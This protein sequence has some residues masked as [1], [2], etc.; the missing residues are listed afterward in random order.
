MKYA[1]LEIEKQLYKL[2]FAE[3]WH[4]RLY[5]VAMLNRCRKDHLWKEAY[6]RLG[7]NQILSHLCCFNKL[8]IRINI[9][10]WEYLVSL[11]EKTDP[12]NNRCKIGA[13]FWMKHQNNNNY[14]ESVICSFFLLKTLLL[15]YYSTPCFFVLQTSTFYFFFYYQIISRSDYFGFR[16]KFWIR[17]YRSKNSPREQTI[18]S[19][20]I[21]SPAWEG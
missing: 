11:N 21:W 14:L 9:T 12:Y 4:L 19:A 1:H 5:T 8:K 13:R 20:E 2:G 16:C 15:F 7:D 6:T 17:F 10:H 18:S 3:K